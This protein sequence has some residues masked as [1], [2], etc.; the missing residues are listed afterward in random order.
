VDGGV[1]VP[2]RRR[3]NNLLALAVLSALVQRPAHPYELGRVLRDWGKDQDM[4]IK[5]GSLYTVVRNLDKHGL[6]AATHS[7]REGARPERTVYEITDEGRAELLDWARELLAEPEPEHPRFTAGLSVLAVLPPAEVIELL[8][9][10]LD[11]LQADLTAR[12]AALAGHAAEIPRLFLVENEYELALR[13]A[14]A[15]WVRTLLD[16]LRSGTYP[17]LVEWTAWHTTGELPAEV[18]R[19]AGRNPEPD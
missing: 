19:L 16:E 1:G 9:R 12:R 14:E 17:G 4:G 10:R 3:V 8:S 11:G 6:I 7:D 13:E 18:M 2:K 15:T 5:W